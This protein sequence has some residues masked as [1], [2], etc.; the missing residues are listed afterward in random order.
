M[1]LRW[2]HQGPRITP[3]SN[4]ELD[5]HPAFTECLETMEV[6]LEQAVLVIRGKHQGKDVEFQIGSLKTQGPDNGMVLI[7]RAEYDDIRSGYGHLT[8]LSH[9]EWRILLDAELEPDKNG[10]VYRLKV[11]EEQ[12]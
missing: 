7:H 4:I 10:H 1:M 2:S 5:G 3:F 6:E 8:R 9:D 11:T 12:K